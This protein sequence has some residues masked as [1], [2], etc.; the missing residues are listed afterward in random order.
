LDLGETAVATSA[1]G[2]VVRLSEASPCLTTIALES[3]TVT[4]HAKDLAGGVL[5][6]R[7]PGG[8]V[9]VHG[10]LFAVTQTGDAFAVEVAEGRV[11]VSSRLGTLFVSRGERALVSA[12]GLA[13]GQL[14][15]ERIGALRA[16]VGAPEVV[17]LDALPTASAETEAPPAVVG[18]PVPA[19]RGSTSASR[20]GESA[21]RAVAAR[22]VEPPPEIAVEPQEAPA[23]PTAPSAAPA[24][25]AVVAN[26]LALAEEARR[27][28]DFGRARQLYRTAGD[29][30]GVTAEAAWLALARMEL[31]L[32]H[33]ELARSATKQRR[34]RFGQG[35]LE[36]EAQWIDV[37][38]YRQTG[39]MAKARE[40]AAELIRRWPSSAQAV[41][42]RR[43]L[44]E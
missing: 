27:A 10:T 38:A 39:D 44:G 28:G 11:S 15:D 25:P 32:G 21:A 4:V 7:A 33:A 40:L 41:A 18:V 14:S 1:P 3:G 16:A 43:W 23:A 9:T 6:V 34:E 19:P 31:S 22:S 20:S 30:S 13:E 29:V 24:A 36:P 17:G 5:K 26:P 37:R 12:V 2:S 8:E 42:A 35:T